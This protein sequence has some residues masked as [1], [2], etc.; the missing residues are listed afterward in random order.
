VGRIETDPNHFPEQRKYHYRNSRF[1]NSE[2]LKT[3]WYNRQI[4]EFLFWRLLRGL[5]NIHACVHRLIQSKLYPSPLK[6]DDGNRLATRYFN[7]DWYR[8]FVTSCYELAVI[9]LLRADDIILVETT[10]FGACWLHQR[11]YKMITCSSAFQTC[12]LGA[13]AATA[14]FDRVRGNH[15]SRSQFRSNLALKQKTNERKISINCTK[16]PAG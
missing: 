9:N 15:R 1:Q 3:V 2:W 10:C 14:R 11:C 6:D 5:V 12:Q 8:L 4:W 13:L 7:K 16:F